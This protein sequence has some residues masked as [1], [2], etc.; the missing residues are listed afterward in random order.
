V[1][2]FF[3]TQCRAYSQLTLISYLEKQF[4]IKKTPER[5]CFMDTSKQINYWGILPRKN[6]I[7]TVIRY[8]TFIC[9]PPLYAI[10]Q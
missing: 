7:A 10:G 2:R 1:G 6:N 8:N 4:C 9:K 5:G 3:E